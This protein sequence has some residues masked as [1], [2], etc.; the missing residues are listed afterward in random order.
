MNLIDF[1]RLQT[2]LPKLLSELNSSE[3][4][5]AW[6]PPTINGECVVD[7][8]LYKDFRFFPLFSLYYPKK[9][10][11]AFIQLLLGELEKLGYSIRCSSVDGG[12]S[13]VFIEEDERD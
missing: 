4:F 2:E 9:D 3:F 1:L 13:V 10:S 11:D 7:E 5:E 8:K 6:D 12:N